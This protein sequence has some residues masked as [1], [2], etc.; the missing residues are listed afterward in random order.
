MPKRVLTGRVVGASN[1]KTIT[2][3]VERRFKHP[4]MKKTMRKTKKFCAH[5]AKNSAKV[6]EIVQIQESLPISKTK[7]WVLLA[8][9]ETRK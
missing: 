7:T 5:D 4:L 1:D 2:V 6:G 3:L 8:D 9:S